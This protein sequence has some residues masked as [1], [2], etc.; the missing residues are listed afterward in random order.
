MIGV[1]VDLACLWFASV[2]AHV[3]RFDAMVQGIAHQ[4]YEGIADFLHDRLIELCLFPRD[5]QL[6]LFAKLL[7]QVMD[8]AWKA[9]ED[10]TDGQHADAHDAFLQF[11]CVAFQLIHPIAQFVQVRSEE[12]RVGKEGA[13]RRTGGKKS[14]AAAM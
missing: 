6:R 10:K 14:D 2:N 3:W 7:A 5:R 4:V 11:T 1:Q 12:R 8:K 9:I 13:L